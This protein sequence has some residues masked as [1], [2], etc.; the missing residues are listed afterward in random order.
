MGYWVALLLSLAL[1]VL[2]AWVWAFVGSSRVDGAFQM[3]VAWWLALIFGCGA[4]FAGQRIFRLY[5]QALRW[6][7]DVLTWNG[8]GG[9]VAMRSLVSL[10]TSVF[11][12]AQ[13]RFA[14]GRSLSVD[15]AAA[16]SS[17]LIEKIE[18]VNGLAPAD[19]PGEH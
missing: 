11:G 10:Q 19:R 7:G 6:R 14:G 16:G 1:S 2:I 15:L 3:R 12:F 18:D 17:D 13:A 5:R 8:S 9:H 4:A